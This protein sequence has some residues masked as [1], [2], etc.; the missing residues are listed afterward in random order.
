MGN[1]N[2][3]AWS[4]LNLKNVSPLWKCPSVAW[5]QE[6]KLSS[7]EFECAAFLVFAPVGEKK[8][9]VLFMFSE[10]HFQ[11]KKSSVLPDC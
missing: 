8:N 3:K 9:S 10:N 6:M 2:L 5:G 11:A 7:D 4:G 1:S